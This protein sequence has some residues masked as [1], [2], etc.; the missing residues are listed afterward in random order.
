M[1]RKQEKKTYK[2]DGIRPIEQGEVEIVNT[3]QEDGNRPIGKSPDFLIPE[4]NNLLNDSEQQNTNIQPNKIENYR[5]VD[6]S[7]LSL[8]DTFEVDGTRPIMT[9]KYRVVDTLDI[10]GQR[11]ITSDD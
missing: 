8:A 5:P 10:D 7:D 11:P 1:S 6:S 2:E 4:R 3:F 9:N